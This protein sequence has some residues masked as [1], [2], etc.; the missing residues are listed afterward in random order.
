MH[1]LR[2]CRF[3]HLSVMVWFALTLGAAIASPI[4]K[5][6]LFDVICSGSGV[7]KVIMLDEGG[8]ADKNADM[9]MDC[10]LCFVPLGVPYRVTE[11][12]QPA[13]DPPIYA[14]RSIPAARIASAT[15]SPLPARGPPLPG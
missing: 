7:V 12:W 5:P 13:S 3:L 15:Q 6:A 10:P 8:A 4:V 11:M 2:T 9:S 1:I 14:L